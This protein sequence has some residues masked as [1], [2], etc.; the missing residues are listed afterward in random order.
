[1]INNGAITIR[2]G[3][4]VR[5]AKENKRLAIIELAKESQRLDPGGYCGICCNHYEGNHTK[6]KCQ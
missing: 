6:H 5:V 2:D 1:M 4:D 3:L